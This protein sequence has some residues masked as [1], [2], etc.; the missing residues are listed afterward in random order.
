MIVYI[1][2]EKFIKF[3]KIRNISV[4]RSK[5]AVILEKKEKIDRIKEKEIEKELELI[6]SK[7]I[8]I[9]LDKEYLLNL[10]NN[11]IKNSRKVKK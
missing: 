10:T 2:L 8:I 9:V 6:I 1:Q 4:Y 5:G 11:I 7:G 3:K